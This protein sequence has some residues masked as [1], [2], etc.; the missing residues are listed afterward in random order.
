VRR[1]RRSEKA[2]RKKQRGL[3]TEAGKRRRGAKK[4]H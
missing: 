4:T 2:K 1:R 3:G